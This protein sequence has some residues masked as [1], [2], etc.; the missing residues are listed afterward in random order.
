M[1][2]L[3][4][5]FELAERAGRSSD[6]FCRRASRIDLKIRLDQAR[7]AAA[8]CEYLESHARRVYSCEVTAQLRA[9]RELA[10]KI[11]LAKGWRRWVSSPVARFISRA[12]AG[13]DSRRSP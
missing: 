7:R 8:W 5:R 13:L 11:P 1:P 9:A 12:G 3:A 10:E 6:R 2:A 4:L